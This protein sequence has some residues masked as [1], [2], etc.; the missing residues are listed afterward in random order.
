M[1][2]KYDNLCIYKKEEIKN[3][4]LNSIVIVKFQE[5]LKE[6]VRLLKDWRHSIPDVNKD[7]DYNRLTVK[8]LM[9]ELEVIW[10]DE[11]SISGFSRIASVV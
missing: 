5:K 1:Q 2:T 6:A 10:K 8:D 4:I 9:T 7:L 3:E 11:I